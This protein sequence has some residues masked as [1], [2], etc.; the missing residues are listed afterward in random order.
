MQLRGFFSKK[1]H[2]N[3][4]F[5]QIYFLLLIICKV[6]LLRG[7]EIASRSFVIVLFQCLK[8]S[9]YNIKSCFILFLIYNLS[10]AEV[11]DITFNHITFHLIIAIVYDIAY[12]YFGILSKYTKFT[13]DSCSENPCTFIYVIVRRHLSLLS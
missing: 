12:T 2:S 13:T 5:N 10:C 9:L 11:N 7:L 3:R 8:P 6:L 4:L 1:T